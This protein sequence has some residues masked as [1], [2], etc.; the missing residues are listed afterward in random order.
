MKTP[1]EDEKRFINEVWNEYRRAMSKFP[2]ETNTVHAALGEERGEVDKD[3][4]EGATREKLRK[5]LVQEAAMCMR[6]AIHGDIRYPM[7]LPDDKFEK[8]SDFWIQLKGK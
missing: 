7:T 4:C 3:I 8:W 2:S 1:N 6:M 5:E